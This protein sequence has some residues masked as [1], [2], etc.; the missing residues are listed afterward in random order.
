MCAR[1]GI[2]H[3]QRSVSC[4]LCMLMLAGT[5]TDV[6]THTFISM[7][8]QKHFLQTGHTLISYTWKDHPNLKPPR[9]SICS[10]AQSCPT[11]CSPTGCSL[12]G[13]SV[14][15]ILQARILERV[16]IS[17]SRGSS[18][19]RDWTCLFSLLHWQAGSLPPGK[20]TDN[21]GL[22]CFTLNYQNRFQTFPWPKPWGWLKFLFLKVI[23]PQTRVIRPTHYML[24]WH[25]KLLDSTSYSCNV[26][27]YSSRVG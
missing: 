1:G 13:S 3:Q 10:A 15:G 26:C 6:H 14:H 5:Q 7:V 24:S 23:S 9:P 20:P 16:A 4:S 19:L 27:N 21:T 12:P 17:F 25:T 22:Y 18:Q 8:I 11:L 2:T